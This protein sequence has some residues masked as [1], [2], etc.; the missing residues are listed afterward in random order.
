LGIKHG[1]YNWKAR[2]VKQISVSLFGEI[3]L[4]IA[5]TAIKNNSLELMSRWNIAQRHI[6]FLPNAE[7]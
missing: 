7:V 5:Q 2:N 4:A 6:I 3:Y 1:L